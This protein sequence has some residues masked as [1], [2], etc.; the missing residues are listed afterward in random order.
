MHKVEN[1]PANVHE[2]ADRH[3][4]KNRGSQLSDPGV[5]DAD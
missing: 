5:T 4:K 2:S 1:S 3:N